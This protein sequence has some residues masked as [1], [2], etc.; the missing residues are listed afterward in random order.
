MFLQSLP[1][2]MGVGFGDAPPLTV[3]LSRDRREFLR[4]TGEEGAVMPLQALV[5]TLREPF[6]RMARH[7]A[8]GLLQQTP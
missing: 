7:K 6:V 8:T 1:E 2:V 3:L 5:G 4:A